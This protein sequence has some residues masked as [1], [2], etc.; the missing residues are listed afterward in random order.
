MA[1]ER[2][3][4][5][6]SASLEIKKEGAL[7][8]R[9]VVN[10]KAELILA[11]TWLDED[12]KVWLY[13]GLLVCVVD[14]TDTNNGVYFLKNKD[15]Y[16]EDTSWIKIASISGSTPAELEQS[17]KDALAEAKQYTDN[18]IAGVNTSITNLTN[19]H[20]SDVT[21][22]NNTIDAL[23]D[24]HDQDVTDINAALDEIRG[25]ITSVEGDYLKKTG[26]TMTGDITMGTGTQI[27]ADYSETTGV[28]NLVSVGAENNYDGVVVGSNNAKT[29]IRGTGDLTHFKNSTS[30][31]IFDEA[32]TDPRNLVF[33]GTTYPV[34]TTVLGPDI[35]TWYAPTTA[36]TNGQILTS[37]GGVPKWSNQSSLSITISQISDLGSTWDTY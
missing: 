7:D 8:A 3:T 23:E 35:V 17:I 31:I 21:T 16:T 33:N 22:I 14:D 11:D 32:N 1:R 10:T 28:V 24:K 27:V 34:L 13:S 30:Y 4:F 5:N 26:G 2:G 15:T 20:N 19:Q 29:Q 37:T 25:N 36:G 12:N 18:E 6:F 9:Q